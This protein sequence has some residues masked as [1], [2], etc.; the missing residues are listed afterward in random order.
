MLQ[1]TS[2]DMW[3]MEILTIDDRDESYVYE[4][5]VCSVSR[6]S[7]CYISISILTNSRQT[8]VQPEHF[9]CTDGCRYDINIYYHMSVPIDQ[10]CDHQDDYDSRADIRLGLC[11]C[12]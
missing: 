7:W 11:S 5:S 2:Q 8:G 10:L 4:T 9:P 12:Q 1:D 6:I 3:S